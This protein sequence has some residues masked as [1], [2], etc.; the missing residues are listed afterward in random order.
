M[1]PL[2]QINRKISVFQNSRRC[3]T[4]D[5][6]DESLVK[7]NNNLIKYWYCSWLSREQIYFFKEFI[8][9]MDKFF[10][11]SEHGTTVRT[12]VLAG[13]N[14]L[15]CHVLY[16]ICKPS[17]A[18]PNRNACSRSISSNHY[19]FSRWDSHDGFLCESALCPS[20]QGWAWTPSLPLQWYLGWAIL[21]K[22]PWE[23]SLF[24]DWFPW[25]SH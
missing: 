15:L 3:D 7:V 6:P 8:G 20:H 5:C 25:L 22:K 19:W 11:L 2:Y 24:A 23:W 16:L 4:K 13:F 1:L 12:E 17:N 10:K 18:L 14:D 21:G 9:K